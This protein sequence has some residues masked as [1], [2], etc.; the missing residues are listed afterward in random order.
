[1]TSVSLMPEQVDALRGLL[2]EVNGFAVE[3]SAADSR[4][5]D[6]MTFTR[7]PE[8]SEDDEAV[9]VRFFNIS[10]AGTIRERAMEPT[11]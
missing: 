7:L 4:S 10:V 11:A 1:M 5:I 9:R 3:I 8:R 2:R 6:A